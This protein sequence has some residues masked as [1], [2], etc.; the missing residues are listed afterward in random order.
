[1]AAQDSR[2]AAGGAL[3]G[4]RLFDGPNAYLPGPAVFAQLR[5]G[6]LA[7]LAGE[8]AGLPRH[9]GKRL[10]ALLEKHF[11][12][13][14]SRD[15]APEVRTL[16]ADPA[17]R[18]AQAVA[19]VALELQRLAGERVG[20]WNVLHGDRPG[21][22]PAICV[23]IET[24]PIGRA[25]VAAACHLV[26]AAALD[27]EP[28]WRSEAVLGDLSV[29][30][31][32]RALA[33]S[34]LDNTMRAVDGEA[35]RRSIPV[36]R[37]DDARPSLQLG[38]GRQQ[39]SVLNLLTDATSQIGSM[40]A[41][42][43]TLTATVLA[44]LGLPTPRHEVVADPRSAV[45][46]ARRIGYPVVVKPDG[47]AQARGVAVALDNDDEVT[48][49]FAL[50]RRHGRRIL[51]EEFIIGDDHRM[52]VIGGRLISTAARRGARV[53]GDGV[54]TVAALI[55]AL[56][57][58]PDRGLKGRAPK[59]SI[60]IDGEVDR[61]LARQ[62]LTLES[63]PARGAVVPLRLTSNLSAGGDAVI[64]DD[65]V[66]P[67]NRAMAEL[68]ARSTGL[69]VVGIDLIT[70]D[71]ARPFHAVRCAINEINTQPGLGPFHMPGQENPAVVAALVDQL[72]PEGDPGT[73]PLALVCGGERAD[74]VV[75]AL[76]D[77]L[78]ENGR[79]PACAGGFGL[80]ADGVAGIEGAYRGDRTAALAVLCHPRADC[81]A[82][83]MPYRSWMD[84][85]T[86]LSSWT[87]LALLEADTP[88]A[89]AAAA[90]LARLHR[91][92]VLADAALASALD[93]VPGE[94]ITLLGAEDD[95]AV[96]AR[97]A[98]LMGSPA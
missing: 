52:M 81:G 29:R 26:E 41:G 71:I 3:A 32:Q 22:P 47:S 2:A 1:M 62:G 75:R 76:H 14:L 67:D 77:R 42:S 30:T 36:V 45:A 10:L 80:L 91:G 64:V 96:A 7:A 66:H 9:A 31:F 34:G 8:D 6:W 46:A 12:M 70:P 23:A 59:A 95:A 60:E 55:A 97:L 72:F 93:G 43:K 56:N 40:L 87:V 90:R 78:L 69:D 48:A 54:G 68:I 21:A 16:L 28:R 98:Q 83:A 33:A 4:A 20:T 51:V 49:A 13:R 58:D 5:P 11:R 27:D 63:V 44:R 65:R 74:A 39:R 17:L 88:D 53:T 37:A 35:R 15:I 84:H 92:P 85:G 25:A 94:R 50:A 38:H 79:H 18:A 61:V 24:R 73:M 57:A 19:L 86:G 89:R 82:L